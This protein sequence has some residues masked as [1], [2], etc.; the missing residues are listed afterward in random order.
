[1]TTTPA[2]AANEATADHARAIDANALA[3][4]YRR[5]QV[6]ERLLLT[7][8]SHQ[9]W[10]DVARDA[11][12]RAWDD[13][14]AHVDGKWDAAFAAAEAVK[15]GYAH[16]L[17]APDAPD[18]G[19]YTLAANTHELLVR[20]L[21]ALDLRARPRLVATDGEFHS[22]RRQLDRLA[23][24]GLEIVDVPVDA[25]GGPDTLAAR[26]AAAVDDRTAA[27]FASSVLF[28][29]ARIVPDLAIAAAAARR[30]GAICVVDA[31]HALNV[32]PFPLAARDLGDAY[33]V[34][35]GYKYAQLGEGCGVLRRPADCRLRPVVTGWF[36]AFAAL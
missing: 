2:P 18:D 34:S 13:A 20:L 27:V 14:A 17:G 24:A 22:L 32:M 1:M 26:L 3:T 8:H 4:H 25:D 12:V 30:V 31:Y 15:R 10:P 19:A 21:S 33:V 36:A 29:T 23:E 28:Q 9:A 7:G 16:L 35:G 5:F 6:G 11:Q